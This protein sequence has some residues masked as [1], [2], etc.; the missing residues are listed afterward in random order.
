MTRALRTSAGTP[1][2]PETKVAGGVPAPEGVNGEPWLRGGEAAR[3]VGARGLLGGGCGTPWRRRTWVSTPGWPCGTV[4][5]CS[6]LPN[7]TA[8]HNDTPALY[9]G[10][11]W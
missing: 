8:G 3:G 11:G 5:E 10:V 7:S 9:R 4:Y 6:V 2:A 1:G